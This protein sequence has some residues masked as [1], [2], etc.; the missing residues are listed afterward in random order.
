MPRAHA[1]EGPHVTPVSRPAE[2]GS[3][4][5]H[6]VRGRARQVGWR[7]AVDELRPHTQALWRLHDAAGQARFLR[8][9]RPWWDVHRHRLAP[10]VASHVARLMAEGRLTIAAGRIEQAR[11]EDGRAIVAWRERHTGEHR[12]TTVD[13]VI[14]CTGP[15]GDITRCDEALLGK[16]LARGLARGDGHRLGLDVDHR[17]R[18]I[19]ADGRCHE[20]LFAVGPMTKGAEWEIVAVPDIR[21]QVWTLARALTNTQWVGGEGL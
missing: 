15:E 14:L 20:A 21:R 18:L 16:L 17:A 6:H 2:R 1:E 9:L 4:L 3:W 12:T 7:H 8:H 5:L 10:A 19:G 13:R 11:E